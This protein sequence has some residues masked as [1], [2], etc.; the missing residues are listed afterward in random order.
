MVTLLRRY[1]AAVEAA[2][3]AP[4]EGLLAPVA[5][6]LQGLEVV[7]EQPGTMATLGWL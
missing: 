2:G 7:V 4:D 1:F 5:E 3:V 6:A